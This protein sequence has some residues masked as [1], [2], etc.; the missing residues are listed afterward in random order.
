MKLMPVNLCKG[1]SLK[2]PNS[3]GLLVLQ[4]LQNTSRS[5]RPFIVEDKGSKRSKLKKPKSLRGRI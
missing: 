3:K 5:S 2:R 4:L 1:S